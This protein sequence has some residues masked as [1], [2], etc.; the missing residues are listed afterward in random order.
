MVVLGLVVVS[1][2]LVVAPGIVAQTAPASL[3][4][5]SALQ[6]DGDSDHL[7]TVTVTNAW[8]DAPS[9]TYAL[10]PRG[11]PA[12]DAD[13][14]DAVVPV[15]VER[16]VSL[17]TTVIP[18]LRDLGVIDRLVAVDQGDYIYDEEVHRRIE[19]GAIIEVGTGE[20]L[21][22]EKIITAR[23]DLVLTSAMGADDLT[24][25]RLS[26]VGVPVIVLAD[27]READPLGR[28]E[29]IRLVGALFDRSNAAVELF[30]QRAERYRSVAALVERIPAGERPTIL[31]NAPWQGSWPVPAGDSYVA[32]LFEDGGGRYLWRDRSG[33]GS[34]FLDVESVMERGGD[35]EF[36]FNLNYGWQERSDITDT[37]PRLGVF[38]SFRSG[39]VYHYI[40]RVRP[41]GAND[42]WESGAARPDLVLSDIVRILHPSVLPDHDLV[43]YRRV[44]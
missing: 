32:R 28:A 36:W 20:S 29:W 38:S 27:W 10:V 30:A 43:Y 3:Q 41:W 21:N 39:T 33:T 44:P 37:D 2:G 42:Y 6:I 7:T 9:L 25:R 14:F 31:V 24:L 15:P 23:P 35:A 4:Y 40:R 1:L 8:P 18:H 12:P 22:V 34:V 13:R 11:E 17:S 19:E 16:L 5:S 26:A